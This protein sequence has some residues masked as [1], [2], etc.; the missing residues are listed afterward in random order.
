MISA[1][2]FFVLQ[3]LFQTGFFSM[4]DD[5]Q[6][7]RLYELDQS[8][9][10][11]HFPVRITQNL[12][13]GYGYAL[14]NFYP[15]FVYYLAELFV[16]V[17]FGYIVSIK[18]LIGFGFV[19]SGITMYMFSREY[20]DKWGSFIASSAYMYAPYHAVDVYVR[21]ALPEFWTFVFI[22]LLFYLYKKIFDTRKI[23]YVIITGIVFCFLIL[24]H[25]LVAM[26]SCFLLSI[27]ILY[28][29]IATRYK[30]IFVFQVLLSGIISLG[31]SASYWLPSFTE[32]NTTLIELL[33]KELADYNQHYVYLRQLW[34]S[35]WGYG[36]SLYGLEDGL[37]FE[38]G[39][40]N[41]IGSVFSLLL[42][43]YLY[44]KK[45]LQFKIIVVFNIILGIAI[46][47][48]TFYSDILWDYF[49]LLSYIQF[50]WRFLLFCVFASSFLLGS[51]TEFFKKDKLKIIYTILIIGAIIISHKNYFQPREYYRDV[52]D[53]DYI[54]HDVIKWKTSYMAFEYVPKG[55]ITEV[56]T[57]NVT[58]IAITPDRVASSSFTILK[59][60]I[61]V[62]ELDVRPHFKKYELNGD[63]GSFRINQ[64]AYPGWKVFLNNKEINFTTNNDYKLIDISVPAGQH[65]LEVQYTDTPIRSFSNIIS[66]TII[67]SIILYIIVILRSKK[68][69]N[70]YHGKTIG[71][72]NN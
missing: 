21:G 67:L 60:N 43:G 25:N 49:K 62:S 26:M 53:N 8:L 55:V 2:A 9:K 59:G 37:S 70:N 13:F 5:E 64:F 7:G 50:P 46:Y 14:F 32:R 30:K 39:K 33:T 66:L 35:P 22:P 34:N 23:G 45:N 3:P 28:L 42:A 1:L 41:I 17:G 65:S 11:G 47:M 4:H 12:G 18:L 68:T 10:A 19:L 71:K 72:K 48:C 20:I 27:Y 36:G 40:I 57:G 38:I 52:A 69:K 61:K 15:P 16:L 29:L 6:V 54:A 31:L 24:T 63:G 51:T 44:F 56:V 58:K